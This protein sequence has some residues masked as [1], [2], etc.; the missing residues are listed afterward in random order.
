MEE[1][2]TEQWLEGNVSFLDERY[3]GAREHKEKRE[4]REFKQISNLN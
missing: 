4:K 2:F 3:K 1:A